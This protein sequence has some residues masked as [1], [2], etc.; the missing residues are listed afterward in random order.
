MYR[1]GTKPGKSPTPDGRDADALGN[2]E[3]VSWLE[4]KSRSAVPNF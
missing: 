4:L 2:E 1:V 3:P